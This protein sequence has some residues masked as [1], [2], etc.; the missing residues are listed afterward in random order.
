[1]GACRPRRLELERL[2]RIEHR[3]EQLVLD[4]DLFERVGGDL[5]GDRGHR[6]DAVAGVNNAGFG[7][8]GWS[9]SDGPNVLTGISLP[10]MTAT[11]PGIASASLVSMPDQRARRRRRA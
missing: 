11:T 8:T 10:V 7:S 6:R 9:F 3:L 2:E 5:L 4:L 1:L